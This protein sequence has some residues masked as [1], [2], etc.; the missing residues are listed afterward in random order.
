MRYAY[1]STPKKS[2]SPPPI[3]LHITPPFGVYLITVSDMHINF[4]ESGP[5]KQDPICN[6]FLE[7]VY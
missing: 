1:L 2:P 3:Y 5:K 6:F 7:K 4:I